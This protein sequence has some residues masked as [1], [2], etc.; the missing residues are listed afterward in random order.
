MKN[1]KID[2]QDL[3]REIDYLDVINKNW[4]SLINSFNY[5]SVI[6]VLKQDITVQK[7]L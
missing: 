7:K 6:V 3:D 2:Y 1:L 4:A 5:D